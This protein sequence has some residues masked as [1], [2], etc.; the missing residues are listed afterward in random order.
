MARDKQLF[1]WWYPPLAHV[2]WKGGIQATD[3]LRRASW[4]QSGRTTATDWVPSMPPL[5]CGHLRKALE[6]GGIGLCFSPD[7]RMLAV[8]DASRIIRLVETATGRT[9][10]AAGKPRPVRRDATRPSAP[11]GRAW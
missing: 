2:R 1:D 10:A 11:T 4:L 5:G 7:S 9:L 3:R 6:V 8:Q